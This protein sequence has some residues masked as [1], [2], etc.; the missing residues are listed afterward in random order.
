MPTLVVVGGKS[1]AW[2]HHGTQALAQVLP[3]AQHHILEGQTHRAKAKALAP[4]LAEFFARSI[5]LPS[6]KAA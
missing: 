2:F 3:N 5:D 4:L 6:T 1:P